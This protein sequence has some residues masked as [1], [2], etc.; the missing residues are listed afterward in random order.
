VFDPAPAG[1]TAD[2]TFTYTS[3]ESPTGTDGCARE[4]PASQSIYWG[5]TLKN[6]ALFLGNAEFVAV[7]MHEIGHYLGLAHVTDA[8]IMRPGQDCSTPAGALSVTQADAQEVVN[9]R[10]TFCARAPVIHHS[11]Y[12]GDGG[13]CQDQYEM[14]DY[15]YCDA[16]GCHTV[17]EWEYVGMTCS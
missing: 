3:D 17:H 14:V 15:D 16:E 11:P 4:D 2:L 8:D 5:L 10:A 7:M 12:G 13:G 6:R 9:C 1:T